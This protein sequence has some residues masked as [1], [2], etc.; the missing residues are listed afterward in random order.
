MFPGIE[1]RIRKE[2][3]EKRP[4][5]QSRVHILAPP[6]RQYSS[7][8]GGSILTSLSTFQRT[9][10]VQEDFEDEGPEAIHDHCII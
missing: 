9:W 2:V 10:L 1:Q 6:R 3:L 7:W 8:I 4:A 5:K